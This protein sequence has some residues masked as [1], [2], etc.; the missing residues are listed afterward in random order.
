MKAGA[1]TTSPATPLPRN[2]GTDLSLSLPALWSRAPFSPQ[3][4]TCPGSEAE[5]T[6][7]LSLLSFHMSLVHCFQH[8]L[9]GK[10]ILH[11]ALA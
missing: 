9:Q 11:E 7:Y 3:L 10:I 8:C 4:C 5:M 1:G 2:Q 6:F